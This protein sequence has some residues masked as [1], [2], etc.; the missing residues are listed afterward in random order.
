[1]TYYLK[2]ELPVSLNKMYQSRSQGIGLTEE[3]KTWKRYA[4]IMAVNQWDFKPMLK[5][6][7]VVSYYFYGS[8]LDIDNGLK[9]LNDSLNN[10]IWEDDSQIVEAHIYMMNRKDK[11]RR[12]EVEINMKAGK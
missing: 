3:A 12:L 8:K 5:G 1:M 11:D 4:S 9:L 6:E 10:I 2:F 7:L